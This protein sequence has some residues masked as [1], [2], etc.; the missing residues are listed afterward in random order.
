[1]S[2]LRG[3]VEPGYRIDNHE[4]EYVRP[5]PADKARVCRYPLAD[6]GVSLKASIEITGGRLVLNVYP[7]HDQWGES[8]LIP[9]S[10][11][12]DVEIGGH[13]KLCYPRTDG[14]G[15]GW[16][17]AG[18]MSADGV[19]LAKALAASLEAEAARLRFLA[20]EMR[21]RPSEVTT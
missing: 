13:V 3:E 19:A 6:F 14:D 12:I 18:K 1:M 10:D 15:K 4:E 11:V 21:P 5:S 16:L 7:K 8:F 2:L 20:E 9:L 17:E